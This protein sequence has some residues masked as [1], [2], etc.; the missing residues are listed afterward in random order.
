MLVSF[1]V[2]AA[3]TRG[4]PIPLYGNA[5]DVAFVPGSH[6]S[7]TAVVSIDNIHKPGSI[8][9]LRDDE[10]GSHETACFVKADTV[11]QNAPRL[12]CFS[13]QA[14]GR[15]Q[16]DADMERVLASLAERGSWIDIGAA[17][18][19]AATRNGAG[20]GLPENKA[21]RDVLYSV[22]NLRKRPGAED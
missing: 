8:T 7:Y 5:L 1:E 3:A 14:D 19:D 16:E 12:Q 2:G 4:S 11:L 21:A 15:W 20:P 22:E 13:K 9:E 17:D 10:V 6:G 18:G